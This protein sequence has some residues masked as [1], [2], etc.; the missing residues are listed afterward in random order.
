MRIFRRKTV[1]LEKN[2]GQREADQ[3]VRRADNALRE[4]KDSV[5]EVARTAAK[6]REVEKRN[7]FARAIRQAMGGT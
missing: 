6:L 1:N 5:P 7:N 3:A 2:D 4:V